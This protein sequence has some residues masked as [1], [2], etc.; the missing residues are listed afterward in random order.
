[1]GRSTTGHSKR[2][3]RLIRTDPSSIFAGDGGNIIAGSLSR[4]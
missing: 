2:G 1:M 4:F 3:G